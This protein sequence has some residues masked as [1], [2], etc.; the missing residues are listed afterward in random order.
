MSVALVQPVS[1]DL[2]TTRDR[3]TSAEQEASGLAK[4]RDSL[5]DQL[6]QSRSHVADLTRAIAEMDVKLQSQRSDNV[7]LKQQV[8]LLQESVE[9]V[10]AAA[11]NAVKY[12]VSEDAHYRELDAALARQAITTTQFHKVPSFRLSHQP[13]CLVTFRLQRVE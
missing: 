2:V 3:L 7:Q 4:E 12:R 5:Q 6:S 9:T 1:G 8:A 13:C 11:E 10:Q